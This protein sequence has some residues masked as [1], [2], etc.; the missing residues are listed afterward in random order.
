MTT[1]KF[2][3]PN[4]LYRSIGADISFAEFLERMKT[5]FGE[6]FFELYIIGKISYQDVVT[7]AT[8][9]QANMRPV[10]QTTAIPVTPRPSNNDSDEINSEINGNTASSVGKMNTLKTVIIIGAIAYIGYLIYKKQV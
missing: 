6:N 1:T 5:T 3:S 10:F 9:K 2:N 8:M 4:K 7:V